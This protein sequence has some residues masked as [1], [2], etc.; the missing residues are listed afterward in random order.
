MYYVEIYK[1]IDMVFITDRFEPTNTE[2][3]SDALT[4]QSEPTLYS[5]SNFMFCLVSDFISA[6]AFGSRHV[7][8][9]AVLQ[10]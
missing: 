5:Y 10:S 6:I 3:G 1:L 9:I 4:T 7:Y 8:L 2:F